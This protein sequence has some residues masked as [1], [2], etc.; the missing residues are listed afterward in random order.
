VVRDPALRARV[1]DEVRRWLESTGGVVDGLVES[2]ITG[3]EGHVEFLISAHRGT[4]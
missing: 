4:V 2:P 3:P 1:C